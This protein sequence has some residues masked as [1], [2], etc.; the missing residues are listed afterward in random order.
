MI[1]C[2]NCGTQN[3][4]GARF[5]AECGADL[6]TV[7]SGSEPAPAPAPTPAF[8]A[9][10]PQYDFGRPPDGTPDWPAG[11]DFMRPP[12]RKRRTWLWIVLGVL[13]ACLVLCCAL[14]VDASTESGEDFVNDISTRL[15]DYQT[16]TAE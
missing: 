7:Q 13:G 14:S 2:P 3:E 15:A 12:A 1:I 10:P 11:P 8:P 4:P 9:I 16:E 6:R 5:C